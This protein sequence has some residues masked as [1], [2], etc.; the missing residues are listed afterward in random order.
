MD[1]CEPLLERGDNSARSDVFA[2]VRRLNEGI[3]E[4]SDRAFQL[5]IVWSQP[6]GSPVPRNGFG[7]V[8]STPMDV[9]QG[10]K[11]REVLRGSL[12]HDF[13]LLLG[14]VELAEM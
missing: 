1:G 14:F 6:H 11:G 5:R 13:E 2:L 8:A 7:Y 3:R 4:F 12:E 9:A 10:A